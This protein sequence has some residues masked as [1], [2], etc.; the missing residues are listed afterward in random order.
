MQRQCV[1]SFP[2]E[3]IKST[4]ITA[5]IDNLLL[6]MEISAQSQQQKHQSK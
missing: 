2:S 6:V 1:I 5:Q 3:V 4:L